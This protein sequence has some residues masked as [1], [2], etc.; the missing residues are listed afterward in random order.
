[1][2]V[3]TSDRER[4]SYSLHVWES[5]RAESC[6]HASLSE[7]SSKTDQIHAIIVSNVLNLAGGGCQAST[8]VSVVK[9][10][11]AF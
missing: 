8:V 3:D 6:L 9:S 11:D 2:Q 10:G 1:M 4:Y 7:E 5:L